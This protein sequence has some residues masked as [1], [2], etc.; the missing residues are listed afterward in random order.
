MK[1]NSSL[2]FR[3]YGSQGQYMVNSF[4]NLTYIHRYKKSYNSIA[5][6]NANNIQKDTWTAYSKNV[7]KVRSKFRVSNVKNFNKAG[8]QIEIL[9]RVYK[10]FSTLKKEAD[11]INITN[12]ELKN[13]MANAFMA[14]ERNFGSTAYNKYQENTNHLIDLLKTVEKALGILNTLSDSQK[15][16]IMNQINKNQIDVK[17][18]SLNSFYKQGF[19]SKVINDITSSIQQIENS[20]KTLGGSFDSEKE[21]L[22]T[23][24]KLI[25]EIKTYFAVLTASDIM[26]NLGKNFISIN[27]SKISAIERLNNNKHIIGGKFIKGSITSQSFGFDSNLNINI[28]TS[29]TKKQNAKRKSAGFK[30]N[31]ET[32]FNLIEQTEGLVS[33]TTYHFMN[34]MVHQGSSSGVYTAIK[35]KMALSLFLET[36]RKTKKEQNYIY[37]TMQAGKIVLLSDYLTAL[38]KQKQFPYTLSTESG[39][40]NRIKT[41]KELPQHYPVALRMV[42]SKE[43]FMLLTNTKVSLRK[44]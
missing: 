12:K 32:L 31:Q 11:G 13:I 23:I 28:S 4:F 20:I 36:I 16:I 17:S 39:L 44:K 6:A 1:N 22:N 40:R 25:I 34:T 8:K 2:P 18:I 5:T 10:D 3:N 38:G 33:E 37:Y 15:E 30:T 35:M 21:I 42:R 41:A 19:D 7:E 29:S 26:Q 27:D 9:E 24:A 43:S 14:P